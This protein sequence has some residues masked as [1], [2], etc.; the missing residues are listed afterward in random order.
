MS[1]TLGIII[2]LFFSFV[3]L[4]IVKGYGWIT[5]AFN[6]LMKM[7]IYLV[8]IAIIFISG[9]IAMFWAV[10]EGYINPMPIIEVFI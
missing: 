3:A 2:L 6:N 1:P 10:R 5:R 4:L 7:I 9:A 8:I